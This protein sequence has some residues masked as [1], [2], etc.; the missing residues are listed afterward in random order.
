V[1]LIALAATLPRMPACANELPPSILVL[2]QA[3]PGLLAYAEMTTHLRSTLN[4]KT[5]NSISIYAESLD[6]SRFNSEHYRNLHT[7]FLHEKYRDIPI[8]VIVV[9]GARALDYALTMSTCTWPGVPVVFA[10]VADGAVDVGAL[11]KNVTG[12]TISVS[13]QNSLAAAKAMVPDLRRMAL[14]GD[15]LQQQTFRFHLTK[16]LDELRSSVDIIDLTGLPMSEVKQR[17]AGLPDDSVIHYTTINV[18]GDSKAFLPADALAQIAA[19]ANRPIV[20]DIERYIGLGATGGFVVHS[21][22]IGEQAGQLV[23]RLFNGESPS[24]IPVS[25]IDAV[26]PVFDWQELRQWGIPESNL[27][28]GSEV[29]FRQLTLWQQYPWQAALIGLIVLIQTGL[30]FALLYEARYRRLAEASNQKLLGR[31]GYLNRIAAAGELTA[32]IAHEVRQPL[33]AIAASGAA[34][35]NWLKSA[36]PNVSEAQ[37]ALQRIVSEAHRADDVIKN[38]R[39]MLRNENPLRTPVNINE[40]IEQTLTLAERRLRSEGVVLNANYAEPPPIVLCNAT[41]IQQVLLNIVV[42]AL[43]AMDAL[44]PNQR[45][46]SVTTGTRGETEVVILIEDTGPG[47]A[48]GEIDNLFKALATTKPSGMGLG[49]AI[50]KS[51]IEAHGGS[52]SARTR[53]EQG[54]T[55]SIVLPIHGASTD[56]QAESE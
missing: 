24:N 6:L 27:P 12:H 52:I 13:L 40:C 35:L 3:G 1:L 15:P 19:V 18:D 46:L 17:V 14:V 5:N 32:S 25:Q 37:A 56:E 33:A 7:A 23:A 45:K 47:V 42:N 11:P 51:I 48:A 55:F 10:A 50:C 38:V 16:E 49:L 53:P 43:E 34:G 2:D 39:A 8:G 9:L 22:L 30:V 44:P 28:P 4:R 54:M 26:K 41:Q 21:K 36:A 29:R 31:I 20:V